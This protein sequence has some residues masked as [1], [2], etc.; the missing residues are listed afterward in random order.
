MCVGLGVGVE[1]E[2]LFWGG[3]RS[4]PVVGGGWRWRF[5]P[6]GGQGPVLLG[7]G[8]GV[9]VLSWGGQGPVLLGVE[10]VSWEGGGLP[11]GADIPSPLWP[12]IPSLQ[13][14]EQTDTCE[15]IS[16]TRFTVRVVIN[17]NGYFLITSLADPRGG[18]APGAPPPLR[19]KIFLISCSFWE[20]KKKMYVGA[21]S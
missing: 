3:S 10:V 19:S 14:V 18:G 15:N 1:V 21:T 2:V 9:E 20:I 8:G 11:L 7:V 6:E 17:L 16:F 5:C 12:D 13:K 4:C